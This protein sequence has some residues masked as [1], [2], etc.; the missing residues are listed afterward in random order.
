MVGGQRQSY[1]AARSTNQ[2]PEMGRVIT[3]PQAVRAGRAGGAERSLFPS[4]RRQT[5]ES[6]ISAAIGG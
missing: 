1:A 2:R 3:C 4:Q 6:Q 5:D